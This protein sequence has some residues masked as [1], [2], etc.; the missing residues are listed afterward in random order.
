M[1]QGPRLQE[2][3]ISVTLGLT[4]FVD[5]CSPQ[6]QGASCVWVKALAR[7]LTCVNCRDSSFLVQQMFIPRGQSCFCPKVL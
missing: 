4:R 7:E 6:A 1:K 2:M 5:S 3:G